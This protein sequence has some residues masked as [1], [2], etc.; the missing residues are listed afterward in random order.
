MVKRVFVFA[1]VFLGIYFWWGHRPITYGHGVMAPYSPRQVDHAG[2]APFP[3]KGY[4]IT[5]LADFQVKARVLSAKR[6]S[7]GREAELSPLDLALGWGPMS[8]ERVLDKLQISQS[9]RF[10]SWWANELPLP[11]NRITVFSA[12]MHMLPATTEVRKSLKKVRKGHIVKFAG[13]LVRVDAADGWH[14][15]SSLTR[16]DSGAGA[17]EMVWVEDF[18]ILDKE[19][20]KTSRGRP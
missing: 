17:C 18:A 10:Y 2:G 20:L 4:T 7:Y 15:T 8:D 1:V 11:E 16:K 19:D 12:N 6:Y 5:P 9:G 3:Y 13:S 14:W